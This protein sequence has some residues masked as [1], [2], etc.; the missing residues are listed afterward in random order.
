MTSKPHRRQ[1]VQV[2]DIDDRLLIGAL[3]LG[4]RLRL[5]RFVEH[6]ELGV[7][8]LQHPLLHL[9]ARL[10]IQNAFLVRRRSE[11]H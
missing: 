5:G 8:V 6:V 7:L 10:Q 9:D 11:S 4:L 1:G 3:A 2:P